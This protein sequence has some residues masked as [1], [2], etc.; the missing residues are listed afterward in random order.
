MH[1]EKGEVI[2]NILL[3]RCYNLHFR[4]QLF[5]FTLSDQSFKPTR[6]DRMV[7]WVEIVGCYT[8]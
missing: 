2:K 3:S 5:Q 1:R 8:C 4:I 6:H 7:G